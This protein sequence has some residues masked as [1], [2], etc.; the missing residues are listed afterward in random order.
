MPSNNQTLVGLRGLLL[1]LRTFKTLV[2][3]DGTGVRIS[4]DRIVQE[5]VHHID[6]FSDQKEAILSAHKDKFN[7]KFT[8]T[9]SK[10]HFSNVSKVWSGG[11]QMD[12]WGQKKL[13]PEEADELLIDR[14]LSL[15]FACTD[16]CNKA[17]TER[18][19]I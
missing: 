17:S 9:E 11:G 16:V 7:N 1:Q 3:P 14:F 4:L 2:H 5:G 12:I 19:Y 6:L 8:A 15:Y 13:T 18:K 10:K